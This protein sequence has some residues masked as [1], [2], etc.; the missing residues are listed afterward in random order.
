V[1]KW[2]VFVIG[3]TAQ[4][5]VELR[6]VEH[7]LLLATHDVTGMVDA[8]WRDV[9]LVH[10]ALP[11]VDYDDIDLSVEFLGRKLESPLF[12]SALTGGHPGGH[13]INAVLAR[14]AERHGLAMGL[15]SQRAGLRNPR[16]SHTYSIAR[17]AAPTAFLVGNIGCAQLI[18]QASGAALGPREVKQAIEMISADAMAIHLNC[19]EEIVQPEGDRRARGFRAALTDLASALSVPVIVK[20]T[21]A[22]ISPTI[23]QIIKSTGAAS[24]DVGGAGGTSY[25]VVEGLRAKAIGDR[26]GERLGMLLG[27]WGVPTAAS[28]AAVAPIG[29]PV[30]A[31]GGIRTGI[32][33]AKAVALGARLVGVSVGLLA[34]A[35]EGDAAVDMWIAQFTRELSAA[36]FL[37][38]CRNLG[39]LQR[40]PRVI[41]GE[42]RDWLDG[43]CEVALP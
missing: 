34:A 22:G 38:G 16:L 12:I 8:G 10:Q 14:A 30:I 26:T 28:V 40:T 18:D 23:G 6:K 5:S 11:E 17:E 9:R 42:T 19:V 13:R 37:T 25:A 20:E 39:E 35:L 21:G 41:V 43:L 31:T 36:M 4:D 32:D 2:G 1:T 24:I 33:A 3:E 27:E 15:G 29:L 7:Q